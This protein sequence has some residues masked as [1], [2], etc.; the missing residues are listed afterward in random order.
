MRGIQCGVNNCKNEI[1]DSILGACPDHSDS[2]PVCL[3]NL[4]SDEVVKMTCGHMYHSVCLY[5]WLD[6][7]RNCPVCRSVPYLNE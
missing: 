1:I 2:C 6:K 5:H 7:A 4:G 3:D